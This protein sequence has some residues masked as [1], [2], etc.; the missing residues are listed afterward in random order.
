MRL[1]SGL[2]VTSCAANSND[3]PSG[4]VTLSLLEEVAADAP[5]M[6]AGL[7]VD[8][9][10]LASAAVERGGHIRVGLEDAPW[11]S[12]STNLE[13]V[14]AAVKAVQDSGCEPATASHVRADLMTIDQAHRES[15]SWKRTG[16]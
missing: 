16:S 4:R 2:I 8:I 10:G 13:W 12:I 7:G 9:L 6:V 5:W 3:D 15:I 14:E 11:N 1:S